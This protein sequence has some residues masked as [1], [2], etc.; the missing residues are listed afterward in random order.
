MSRE[1][2]PEI[3][4]DLY[5]ELTNVI[6]GIQEY[7]SGFDPLHGGS[8]AKLALMKLNQARM[9]YHMALVEIG[10]LPHEEQHD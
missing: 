10:A 7:A 4:N 3:Y 1:V 5:D 6:Q 8:E 9:L 2:T